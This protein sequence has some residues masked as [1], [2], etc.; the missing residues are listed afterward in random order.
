MSQ[1][2]NAAVAHHEAGHAVV[3]R[4]LGAGVR[5]V[6]LSERNQ[7]Q[8]LSQIQVKGLSQHAI[9][10][11][12]FAGSLAEIKHLAMAQWGCQAT[13]DLS[14]LDGLG[15]VAYEED[16]LEE[17]NPSI[18]FRTGGEQL[19]PFTPT[20][21]NVFSDFEDFCTESRETTSRDDFFRSLCAVMQR[22]DDSVVWMH[23][24][25]VAKELL[26]KGAV[27]FCENAG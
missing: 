21:G 12:L 8:G 6:V 26:E 14:Q 11:I 2:R 10:Q 27:M 22:L 16:C 4:L 19:V 20:H 17:C 13:F 3:A 1:P 25:V 24:Q 18:V 5:E 9:R 15:Q 7:E 23:V